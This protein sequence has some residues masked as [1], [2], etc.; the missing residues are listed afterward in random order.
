MTVKGNEISYNDT[1]D[2]EGMLDNRPS[3]GQLRSRARPV[4]QS[5]CGTVTPDGDQGGFKLWRTNGV[6]IKDNYIHSNWGPGIWADTDNANTT[7]AGNM[8]TDND[9][10]AIIE[11]ISYNFVDHGNYMADNGWTAG[12]GNPASRARPSTS[13]RAAATG[14]SAGFRPARKPR[15]R[16][17]PRTPDQSVIS[18]NTF[19]NNGGNVFLWQNSDRFCSAGYDSVC[20]LA[21]GA[22][23]G[24]FT[25]SACKSNLR[26]A[27]VNTST[28]ASRRTGSPAADWWDG[29]MWRS[30]NVNISR[31]TIDFNPSQI[32]DCNAVDWPDCGPAGSLPN[33]APPRPTTSPGMGHP[34]PAHVFRA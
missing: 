31:N 9:G 5:H 32:L 4:P 6:T 28:Y 24:P 3:A 8:I 30:S 12:L 21:D 16:A 2:F 18:H 11:E 29:C 26:S 20:T 19:V 7:Y 17:S 1:C 33:T 13:A 25:I 15:A 23:S 14:R 10:S 22:S 34:Q 27:S